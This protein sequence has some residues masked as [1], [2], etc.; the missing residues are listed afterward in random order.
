LKILRFDLKN[1]QITGTGNCNY[2]HSLWP[3]Y[4]HGV[5][6][7]IGAGRWEHVSR[8]FWC[9]GKISKQKCQV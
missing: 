4:G 1:S 6:L 7:C 3:L 9:C 8:C 5:E 2:S